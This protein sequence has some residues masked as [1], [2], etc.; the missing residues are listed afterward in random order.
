MLSK[1]LLPRKASSSAPLA[2][3]MWTHAGRFWTAVLLV[4]FALVAEEA[5]RVGEALDLFAA[6]FLTDVRAGVLVVVF[7]GIYGQ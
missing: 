6:G 3:T 2:I 7:S 1:I 5:A 4:D